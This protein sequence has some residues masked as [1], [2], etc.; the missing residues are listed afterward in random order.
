MGGEDIPPTQSQLHHSLVS[1]WVDWAERMRSAEERNYYCHSFMLQ[2]HERI[3][4]EIENLSKLF[5][6][7]YSIFEL[8]C[9]EVD[10]HNELAFNEFNWLKTFNGSKFDAHHEDNLQFFDQQIEELEAELEEIRPN[11]LKK[12]RTRL[13]IKVEGDQEK[14]SPKEVPKAKKSVPKNA[15]DKDG[16]P[17]RL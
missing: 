11:L 9:L 13:G 17:K 16:Y 4:Q 6:E 2:S 12:I 8:E 3:H 15:K 7:N 10:I 5:F 1:L 14:N